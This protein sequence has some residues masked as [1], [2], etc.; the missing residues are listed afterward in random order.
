MVQ[1][2]EKLSWALLL[3]IICTASLVLSL[4]LNFTTPKEVGT[5]RLVTFYWDGHPIKE[6]YDNVIR[7]ERMLKPRGYAVQLLSD[8]R[9]LPVLQKHWPNLATIFGNITIPAAK[10][11]IVRYAWLYRHGGF[12]VDSHALF[13]NEIPIEKISETSYNTIISVWSDQ[14]TCMRNSVMVS[15][16]RSAFFKAWLDEAEIRLFEHFK[17]ECR[18]TAHVKYD[19]SYLTGQ[20][21]VQKLC[22][23]ECCHKINVSAE[24]PVYLEMKCDSTGENYNIGC[25]TPDPYFGTYKVAFNHNHGANMHL[26][27]SRRQHSQRLFGNISSQDTAC[28]LFA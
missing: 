28:K 19:V 4:E 27:W 16:P 1:L 9:I 12:Y 15:K 14:Q 24:N 10:S 11:D 7:T 26:H 13:M 17:K 23:T 6:V 20:S 5:A 8:E 25:F 18:T 2:R 3:G 21:V 22:G